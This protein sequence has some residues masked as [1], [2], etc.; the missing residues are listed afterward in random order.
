MYV[1]LELEVNCSQ[2]GLLF[3]ERKVDWFNLIAEA[4]PAQGPV[5][6]SMATGTYDNWKANQM[7]TH[8]PDV[9]SVIDTIPCC[10]K[11]C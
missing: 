3:L 4:W 1:Y 10:Q 6:Q 7:L 2:F 5:N 11:T 8:S 9:S